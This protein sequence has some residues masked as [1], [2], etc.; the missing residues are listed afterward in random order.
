[1]IEYRGVSRAARTAK[2]M[3]HLLNKMVQL[4]RMIYLGDYLHQ[5][6]HQLSISIIL[7]KIVEMDVVHCNKIL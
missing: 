7:M 6:H 3:N 5:G 2:P 4:K 1:M